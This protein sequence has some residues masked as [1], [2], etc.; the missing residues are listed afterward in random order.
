MKQL[1]SKILLGS[2]IDLKKPHKPVRQLEP[3]FLLS[4]KPEIIKSKSESRFTNLP[5]NR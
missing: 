2:T 1:D 3:S 5:T 4:G